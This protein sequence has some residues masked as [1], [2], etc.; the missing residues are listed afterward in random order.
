MR[1]VDDK[2]KRKKEKKKKE[3]VNFNISLYSLNLDEA[4]SEV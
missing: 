2:K 3:M 4:G 1:R